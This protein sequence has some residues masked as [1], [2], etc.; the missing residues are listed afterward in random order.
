MFLTVK[1]SP[2]APNL[3]HEKLDKM[4]PMSKNE[5]IMAAT[6]SLTVIVIFCFM[7]SL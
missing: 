3:A 1:S 2:G 6:F 5:L 4:G 7:S